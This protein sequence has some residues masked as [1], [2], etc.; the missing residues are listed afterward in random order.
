MLTVKITCARCEL[1][2]RFSNYIN[3]DGTACYGFFHG[4]G[5]VD[6][7]VHGEAGSVTDFSNLC[8]EIIER[9]TGRFDFVANLV[10]RRIEC[11]TEKLVTGIGRFSDDLAE[12]VGKTGPEVSRGIEIT[13]YSLP[14]GSPAGTQRFLHGSY[15]LGERTDLRRCIFSGSSHLNDRFRLILSIPLTDEICFGICA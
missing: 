13:K 14:S 1:L 5:F 15:K 6:D 12:H 8:L 3:S 7:I 10:P 4:S 2:E 11:L 9:C